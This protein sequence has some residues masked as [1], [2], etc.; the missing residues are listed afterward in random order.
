MMG[1]TSVSSRASAVTVMVFSTLTLF[2][3]SI[4]AYAGDSGRKNINNPAPRKFTTSHDDA[5]VDVNAAFWRTLDTP[6]FSYT[7]NA[8]NDGHLNPI[9][10]EVRVI[11]SALYLRKDVGGWSRH[12]LP[13][14]SQG[15]MFFIC[16]QQSATRKEIRYSAWMHEGGMTPI[17]IWVS[18]ATGKL[19]RTSRNY[20]PTGQMYH[21]RT[22]VQIFNYDLSKAR[23]PEQYM[24]DLA[25]PDI[26][27]AD[28][29]LR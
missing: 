14:T 25:L 24:S 20:S 1:S 13:K 16:A 8:V 22:V 12:D 10:E 11:D 27:A 19:V 29:D 6:Q 9:R 4:C 28:A 17:D 23:I 2:C 5:C 18:T 7:I 15:A 3:A 21:A 26:W